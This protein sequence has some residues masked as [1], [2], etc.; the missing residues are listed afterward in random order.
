MTQNLLAASAVGAVNA[1]AVEIDV[2]VDLYDA[3][4]QLLGTLPLHLLPFSH[5]H[6]NRV[7]DTAGHPNVTDG[8]AIVRNTTPGGSCVPY[9]TVT[10][11]V[12]FDA[13]HVTSD[14]PLLA[15]FA[16][17]FESGDTSAWSSTVP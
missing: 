10:D 13:Y 9:A 7:F 16:D 2:A 8:F 3:S 6:L 5:L 12:T 4:G 1:S 15:V 14:R 17:G 11:L